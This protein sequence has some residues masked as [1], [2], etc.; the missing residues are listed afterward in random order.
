MGIKN[1]V[2]KIWLFLVWEQEMQKTV[3][4]TLDIM[5]QKSNQKEAQT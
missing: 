4:I 2:I 5:E 3:Q 1:I